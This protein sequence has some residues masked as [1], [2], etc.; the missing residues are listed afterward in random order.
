MSQDHADYASIPASERSSI[1]K[2]QNLDGG[3]CFGSSIKWCRRLLSHPNESPL[4]RMSHVVSDLD[5]AATIQFLQMETFK[6]AP[7]EGSYIEK[8]CELLNSMCRVSRFNFNFGFVISPPPETPTN[9]ATTVSQIKKSHIYSLHLY[10]PP[11]DG[12]NAPIG[13]GG[14][15]IMLVTS[16]DGASKVF[17]ANMGEIEIGSDR[18]EH[19]F[20]DYWQFYKDLG[21]SFAFVLAYDV[22][23]FSES[24]PFQ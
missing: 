15:A 11:K 4:D 2:R 6:Y 7:S 17:D 9:I 3:V 14:H 18:L 16:N 8:Q 21:R 22:I 13:S 24:F 10:N 19:F 23:D 12:D 1:F 5:S 20:G